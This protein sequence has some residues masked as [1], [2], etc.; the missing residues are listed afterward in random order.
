MGNGSVNRG[1]CI[2]ARYWQDKQGSLCQRSPVSFTA[3]GQQSPPGMAALASGC[4][5]AAAPS[6]RT[7]FACSRWK[8][9]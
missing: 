4:R 8:R 2:P 6:N 7:D 3:C 1:G 5:Y 9:R